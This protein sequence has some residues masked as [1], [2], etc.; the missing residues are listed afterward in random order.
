M[1]VALIG[2][3]VGQKNNVWD[4]DP[5]PTRSMASL[6]ALTIVNCRSHKQRIDPDLI[7]DVRRGFAHLA[8]STQR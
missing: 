1:F 3:K 8:L 7:K 6:E 5:T 4:F 2:K